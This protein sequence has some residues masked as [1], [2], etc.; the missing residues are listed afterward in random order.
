MKNKVQIVHDGGLRVLEHAILAHVADATVQQFTL[1]C[2][3]TLALKNGLAMC[4]LLQ[5]SQ[6][7][8]EQNQDRPS[9]LSRVDRQLHPAARGRGESGAGRP[10]RTEEPQL[11][12]RHVLL[13]RV[14]ISRGA[15]D[16]RRL[17]F[18]MD[19]TALVLGILARSPDNTSVHYWGMCVLLNL[20]RDRGLFRTA[21]GCLRS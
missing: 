19:C 10:E 2:L 5:L 9:G 3:S 16:N 1:A 17:L 20:A 13:S 12:A 6:S 21:P 18:N 7:R 14:S 8:H 15:E 11:A 4:L